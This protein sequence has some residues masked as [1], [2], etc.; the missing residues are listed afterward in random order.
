MGPIVLFDKSA[1]E[2]LSMDEATI[3]DCLFMTN[4]CPIYFVEVLADLG[5]STTSG[6]SH[7]KVVSDISK[8]TPFMHSYFN[9]WHANLSLA[10]LMGHNIELRNVPHIAG[11]QPVRV[12]G[13]SGVIFST[14]PEREAMDRWQRHK[15]EELEREFASVWR[16]QLELADLALTGKLLKQL[17]A[18]HA[19]PKTEH[20]I[21][22]IATEA[23]LGKDQ[24]FTTLKIAFAMLGLP[25][26]YWSR[27][28]ERWQKAGY[29]SLTIYAPYT[30]HCLL[31]DVFFYLAIDKKIISPD[32]PSNRTDFTYLYYLP[33]A[34]CFSS[35]YSLLKLMVLLFFKV[36]QLFPYCQ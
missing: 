4:I 3:F 29:Q 22:Q 24:E 11:G 18:Q 36:K 17:L 23:V 34:E 10:E 35:N 21:Y 2:M 13:K 33:F 20:E 27:V 6:R 16:H 19:S 8:K 32:R 25:Q 9:A 28:L 7:E 14:P 31:V 1:I 15:F 30:A 26:E 5:K 12:K